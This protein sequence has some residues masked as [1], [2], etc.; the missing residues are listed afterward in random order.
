MDCHTIT[1]DSKVLSKK[2]KILLMGTPNVGKSVFFSALT[3]LNVISSNYT[4]TTVSYM[5]G[6]YKIGDTEYTLIDVPGTYSLSATSVAEEVAVRFMNSNPVAVLFVLNAAD[7]EGSIK[8]ALEVLEYK[9]PVVFAL[10][11]M[12]VSERKGFKINIKL[13]EQELGSSVIPTVAV[14]NQG[15]DEITETFE[16]LLKTKKNTKIDLVCSGCSG[17]SGCAGCGIAG[18]NGL[19]YW[20]RARQIVRKTV[21]R[22]DAKPNFLDRLGDALLHPWPGIPLALMILIISLGLVVGGGKALRSIV[23]L[24]LVNQG[25]V[26]L[27]ERLITPLNLHPILHNIL[28]GNYGMFRISFEWIL[29]LVVPYVI[30]FQVQFALLEDSGVLPRIAVLFDNLMRKLG[31]QGGSLIHVFLGFGCAVPAII[32]TRT[33][34]TQKERLMVTSMVCFAI[35]CI[36]Q[37][38]AL[39][40]LL[41][42][43][44]MWLLL[45]TTLTGV[46]VFVIVAKIL[47]RVLKGSVD[48]LIL[49]VPNLLIPE[50]RAY[51]K[52]LWIRIKQFLV[53]AEGPML[54]AVF[55]AAILAETGVLKG[56]GELLKP[57]ISGWLGLPEGAVMSLILGIIRREMSVAPLLELSLTPL[58]MYVGAVVSLL[59]LPCLSVFGI[60]AKEFNAKIAMAI[61]I[62]TT[63]TALFVGGMMNHLVLLAQRIF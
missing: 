20:E 17:C 42:E 27:F 14:K 40:S 44:S 1:E 12:D 19:D 59:Y 41:S 13:L 52:K 7:L 43:Y 37:T 48:P 34:T 10:N 49:E 57:V 11:L 28:I 9:I 54:I 63:T 24:P 33:A 15:L 30:L 29:A 35:P 3:K 22:T 5:E 56:L 21:S 16:Q 51:F 26:P 39:I 62:G 47:G 50:P 45:A 31:V 38:G 4:G 61:T 2:N 36:S 8:L 60:I 6:A 53:E 23:L 18:S 46:G 58:Q 25:I 32:G 55:I